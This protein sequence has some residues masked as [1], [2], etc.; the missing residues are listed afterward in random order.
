[1]TE[2]TMYEAPE[3]TWVE[4]EVEHGFIASSPIEAPSFEE[5]EWI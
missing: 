3:I 2:K 5:D 4:V 1:M